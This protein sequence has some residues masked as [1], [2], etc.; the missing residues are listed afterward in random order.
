MGYPNNNCMFISIWV[1]NREL[2][3]LFDFLNDRI[4][5]P[6]SYWIDPTQVPPSISG[7]Y[8]MVSLNYEMFSKIRQIKDQEINDFI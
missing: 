2:D 8:I 5:E 7:G 1:H 3:Q 6:P 4:L